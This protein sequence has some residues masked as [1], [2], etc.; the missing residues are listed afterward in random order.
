MKLFFFIFILLSV[1]GCT[2]NISI[3]GF[4]IPPDKIVE[5]RSWVLE[6][7]EKANPKADEEPEDM[8][9]QCEITAKRLFGELVI[10]TRRCDMSHN[11]YTL[12]I[13]KGVV[14]EK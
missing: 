6:C 9:I 14:L 3:D 11:C 8:I 4:I 5:A 10:F 12:E 13:K 7:L 1:G 2:S